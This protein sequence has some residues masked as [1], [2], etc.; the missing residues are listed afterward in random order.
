[1][2][3]VCR[4]SATCVEVEAEGFEDMLDALGVG[5]LLGPAEVWVESVNRVHLANR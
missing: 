4:A 2:R 3:V 1:M 5:C